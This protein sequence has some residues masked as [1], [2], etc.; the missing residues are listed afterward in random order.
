MLWFA[1]HSAPSASRAR[2]ALTAR[3]SSAP[4]DL[5][6]RRPSCSRLAAT[7]SSSRKV[8]RRPC[9]TSDCG[10]RGGHENQ[11]RRPPRPYSPHALHELKRD[12]QPATRPP[13]GDGCTAPHD[14]TVRCVR[15]AIPKAVRDLALERDQEV[16]PAE[17][18]RQT[19]PRPGPSEC[20]RTEPGSARR[21]APTNGT[22]GQNAAGDHGCPRRCPAS[23][24]EA[25]EWRN[26][27]ANCGTPGWPPGKLESV[28]LA[29]PPVKPIASSLTHLDRLLICGALHDGGDA[30]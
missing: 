4:V 30:R 28:V 3:R 7:W 13:R 17:A 22:R 15:P 26:W 18:A 1:R 29:T 21:T 2:R 11:L 25:R 24:A 16:G 20:G 10:R 12:G 9:R 27:T 6:L 8:S 14:R 5:S 23:R 19:G